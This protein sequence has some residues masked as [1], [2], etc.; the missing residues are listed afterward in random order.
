MNTNDFSL[1]QQYIKGKVNIDTIWYEEVKWL[2]Q[3]KQ[4]RKVYEIYNKSGIW[5][6]IVD[7]G[8]CKYTVN[9]NIRN[10]NEK[11]MMNQ[12]IHHFKNV[13]RVEQHL[14]L[15]YYMKGDIAA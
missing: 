5:Y 1:L 12:F 2:F 7:K 4:V 14:L 10:S 15:D 11:V 13:I 3:N 6:L 8:N 9:H